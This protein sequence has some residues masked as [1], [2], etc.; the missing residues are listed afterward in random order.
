MAHQ[1]KDLCVFSVFHCVE[2]AFDAYPKIEKWGS[3]R[4]AQNCCGC[5]WAVP[6]LVERGI[7]PLRRHP[8]LCFSH[9]ISQASRL[10]IKYSQIAQH[11]TRSQGHILGFGEE[12]I[13]PLTASFVVI[14]CQS[15]L[16]ERANRA[17]GIVLW[18]SQLLRLQHASKQYMWSLKNGLN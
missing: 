2:G 13:F 1:M 6:Y 9:R 17:L 11:M 5:V 4:W 12:T 10:G 15:V 3:A 18:S 8:C 14:C 7:S 16:H